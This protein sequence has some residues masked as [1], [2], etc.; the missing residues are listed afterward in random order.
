M[1]SAARKYTEQS[2]G[3]VYYITR[4]CMCVLCMYVNL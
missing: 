2:S 3:R 4:T 1:Q